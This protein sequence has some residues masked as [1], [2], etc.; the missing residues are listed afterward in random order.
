MD[1]RVNALVANML[2]VSSGQ[3]GHT[4]DKLSSPLN[5]FIDESATNDEDPSNEAGV[6]LFDQ[7]VQ[8]VERN[9]TP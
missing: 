4:A 7:A 6:F 2:A 1:A 9:E 8:D 3:R 5:L